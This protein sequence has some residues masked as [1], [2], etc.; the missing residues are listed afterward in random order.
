MKAVLG[1]SRQLSWR[2]TWHLRLGTPGEPACYDGRK[3]FTLMYMPSGRLLATLRSYAHAKVL[4]SEL[5]RLWYRGEGAE[6]A[7][8]LAP[9]LQNPA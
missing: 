4:A 3:R 8:N 9:V 1:S 2:N 5:A 6:P 7:G